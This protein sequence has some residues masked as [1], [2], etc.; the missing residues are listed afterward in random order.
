ME[1]QTVM[2]DAAQ[3]VHHSMTRDIGG[4]ARARHEPTAPNR[5]RAEGAPHPSSSPAPM[6]KSPKPNTRI[7]LQPKQ[8]RHFLEVAERGAISS[9]SEALN[10]TQ[11]ALSKSIKQLELRL[12]VELFDR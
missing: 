6:T 7:D 11:P 4:R 9:A 12:G 10:I 8:L 2:S 1:R 3:A 5:V